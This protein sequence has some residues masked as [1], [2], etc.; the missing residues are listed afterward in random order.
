MAENISCS[1]HMKNRKSAVSSGIRTVSIFGVLLLSL[2]LIFGVMTYNFQ[3]YY[4]N[5]KN[6]VLELSKNSSERNAESIEMFFLRHADVLLTS[7]E[8]LEYAMSQDDVTGEKVEKLLRS[9]SE[10][11]NDEVYESATGKHFTGIY[12]SVDGVLVHGMRAF[13][14]LEEGYNPLNR[15][16]YKEG[17]AGGGKLVFGEPYANTYDSSIIVMTATKLLADGTT[18]I[19]M[20]ITMDDLQTM[21]GDMN[22]S[23]AV[24]GKDHNYGY[25]FVITENGIVMAH[26]EDKTQQG[27]DYSKLQSPMYD[28]FE[29]VKSCADSKMHF[30]EMKIDGVDY[31]LY[32]QRLSNGWYTVA[33]VDLADIETSISSLSSEIWI[34]T[35]AVVLIALLYC[36]VITRAYVKSNKMSGTLKSALNMAMTDALTGISNR[37]AFD[38]RIN[39]LQEKL[40]TERDESYALIMLDLNDLKY[41]ND[42]HGHAA[43][44]QYLINSCKLVHEVFSCDI[45]RIGGDEFALFL[46]GEQFEQWESF[47]DQMKQ[48]VEDANMMLTPEVEQPS[49]AIGL[50]IHTAGGSDSLDDLMRKADAEMYSNK[51]AIKQARLDRSENKYRSDVKNMVYDKQVLASD[52]QKGIEEKQ[53][54]IWFQPQVNHAN[55]GEQIGAEALV[56]WRHPERGLISPAVFIPLLEYNELIYELDKYVWRHTCECIRYWMDSGLTALPISVNVSRRDLVQPDFIEVITSLVKEWQIPYEMLHLEV[57]ETAFSDESDRMRNAVQELADRGFIIAI[58][59]FGS[60]YSSLSVLRRIPAHIVKL[61]MRFFDDNK[62]QARN[63]CILEAIISMVKKLGMSVIAEVI[64]SEEQADMLHKMGCDNIQGYLYSKPLPYDEYAAYAGMPRS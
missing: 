17:V 50:A 51:L 20:D 22:I 28:V 6:D 40:N 49:I 4:R 37:T 53:F 33:L 57:T 1:V 13:S 54:E 26:S 30:H 10:A 42:H 46:T 8:A 34:V 35:A 5:A 24:N 55:N 36:C 7:A 19:G 12:A 16:W 23:V 38:M 27:E 21:L 11:Y 32:A 2:L 29:F 3:A 43:G 44:D 62:N 63:E 15:P 60:G 56:R 39:E 48:R 59:D 18:V 47:Y 31:G 58:D 64:E 25:G 52:V 14:E 41:I 9:I 61:D 45:Y